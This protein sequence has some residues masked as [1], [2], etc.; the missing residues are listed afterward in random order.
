MA[1]T[2]QPFRYD[3]STFSYSFL[4]FE[5]NLQSARLDYFLVLFFIL[6]GCLFPAYTSRLVSGLG[7]V[8]LMRL[9][10]GVLFWLRLFLLLKRFFFLLSKCCIVNVPPLPFLMAIVFL[11]HGS[12]RGTSTAKTRFRSWRFLKLEASC[13]DLL[14]SILFTSLRLS[15]SLI[16]LLFC[17]L[18]FFFCGLSSEMF[19]EGMF[20]PFF[21]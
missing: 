7:S 11:S 5:R 21:Y 12:G 18:R 9:P 1:K 16:S 2:A 13:S 17:F 4:S 6:M 20:F 15:V 8:G 19:V 10:H 14:I 3:T